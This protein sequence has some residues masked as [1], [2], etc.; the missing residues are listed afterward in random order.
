MGSLTNRAEAL[1]LN[2]CLKVGNY[3]PK[4]NIYLALFESDPTDTGG[5][6][7][8]TNYTSYARTEITF[9]SAT[10]RSS[11]QAATVTFPTATGAATS[12][13]THWGVCESSTRATADILAHGT[14]SAAKGIVPG[15]TPFVDS[16]SGQVTISF[17]AGAV[18]TTFANKMLDF[19]FRNQSLT[20]GA[21]IYMT[22]HSA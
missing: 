16:A 15:K 10:T 3:T 12:T 2:H 7:G 9:S 22:L 19:M 4:T 8:E 11:V 6:A 18:Y 20:T 1:L 17:S 21:H 13:V 14:L 5:V